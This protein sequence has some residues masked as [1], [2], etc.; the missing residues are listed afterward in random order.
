[1]KS[2]KDSLLLCLMAAGSLLLLFVPSL[3]PFAVWGVSGPAGLTAAFIASRRQ[4]RFG[5][6]AST[7]ERDYLLVAQGFGIAAAIL[8]P[9]FVWLLVRSGRV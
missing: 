8:Y 1:M 2:S 7:D 9:L 4:R 3:V 5:A 6:A